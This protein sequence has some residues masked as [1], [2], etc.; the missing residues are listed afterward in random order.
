M[1][2]AAVNQWKDVLSPAL[3]SGWEAAAIVTGTIVLIW[4]T[5]R[6]RAWFRDD[7]AHAGHDMDLL[8]D[9]RELHRQGGLSEDEFRLIRTQ[10]MGSPVGE[11]G[12]RRVAA[13]SAEVTGATVTSEEMNTPRRN[14]TLHGRSDS[15]G[16]EVVEAI[17]WAERDLIWAK[18]SM[19]ALRR[20]VAQAHPRTC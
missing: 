12:T 11:N 16:Q 8:Q 17:P 20:I 5:F 4:L 6:I 3:P 13:K 15:P 19:H 10:L 18:R 2:L 14:P 9:L 1:Y 7:D